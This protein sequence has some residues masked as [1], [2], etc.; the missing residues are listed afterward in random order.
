MANDPK[1]PAAGQSEDANE[2][3]VLEELLSSTDPE[4]DDDNDEGVED[5]EK[6][7]EYGSD[8]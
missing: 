7:L 4:T 1:I 2:M 8:D 3:A 6:D 5:D